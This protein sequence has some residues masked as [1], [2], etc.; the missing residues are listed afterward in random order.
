MPHARP[1]AEHALAHELVCTARSGAVV[2]R[3]SGWFV[4]QSSYGFGLFPMLVQPAELYREQLP[5]INGQAAFGLVLT[6]EHV[7]WCI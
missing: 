4:E 5:D 6:C 1:L 2:Q 3:L 7:L